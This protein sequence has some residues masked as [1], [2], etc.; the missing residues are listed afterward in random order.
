MKRLIFSS[1]ILMLAFVWIYHTAA[2]DYNPSINPIIG[3][4]SYVGKFG[5][6]P[7]PATDENVRIKTHLAY[8]EMILRKSGASYLD[9][10]TRQKREKLLDHLHDYWVAGVFPKNYDRKNERSPC[11]IDKNGRI[12]AV[13]YLI[14]KSAGRQLAENINNEFKYHKIADM[15][16][17]AL[18]DWITSSG[19]TKEEAAIIQPSY[20]WQP[21]EPTQN[22]NYIS[23]SYGISSSIFG[24][25]NLSVSAI[26]LSNSSRSRIISKIG[27][28][29]GVAQTGLGLASFPRKM[30]NASGQWISNESKKVLSMINIGLGTGTILLSTWD[31]IANKPAKE[32]IYS[33]DLYSFP[34][35][36]K[37]TGFALSVKR[38][39]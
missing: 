39:F 15:N 35:S 3:D 16:S 36:E 14:E 11:F 6:L 9:Q 28:V 34:L 26:Q 10:E 4:I 30:K 25:I 38:K 29:S 37:E 21:V 8:A 2:T 19:F 18:I 13:G 33:W 17:T 20:G 1:S 24:G 22:N 27:L 32:K 12:C 31:L 23:T 7:T 5:H